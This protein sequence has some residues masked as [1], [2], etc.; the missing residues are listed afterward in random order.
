MAPGDPTAPADDVDDLAARLADP[1]LA[2]TRAEAP[3]PGDPPDV[4][5]RLAHD[6]LTGAPV[7]PDGAAV[8]ARANDL[9]DQMTTHERLHLLSGDGR[10]VRGVAEMAR[11]YNERP[12]VAGE[13]PRLGIPG[14]RFSDGPRGVVVGQATA[15][16][17]AM[18]RGASFD[19]D[20]EERV[21]DAMGA[22]CRALGANLFAGVC[23]N[24][25][26]HPAWGRAQETFG[27]DPHLLGEMGA[28]LVRGVQ[29][30]VMACV[31]HFACN[32]MEDARFRVD[33]S[34]DEDDLR[35]I[36]LP[37]FRRCVDEG[38]AAV[39][40]AYNQVNG[41]WCGHS[42]HL[43]GDVLKGEWDFDGFVM[44]DFLLGVRS[45]AAVAAGLDVEMPF[46][47]RF[48]SLGRLVRRGKVAGERVDDAARRVLRQQVR[49]AARAAQAA[50]SDG[51]GAARRYDPAVVAGEAHRA[52][53]REVAE[54]SIVLLRNETVRPPVRGGDRVAAPGTGEP[55][56]PFDPERVESMA[57]L[58]RLAAL[59]VTG[60]RGSSHVRAPSV[61]TVLDGLRAAGDRWVI[62]VAH[63]PGDDLDAARLAATTADVAVVVAGYTH[64]DEGENVL[65]RGGDRRSLTLAPHDEALIRTVAAVNPRTAVVLIGGSAIVT[66]SWREQVGAIL[67]A[68]YPGMEGG[69]ALARVLFGEV[70]PGGRLPCT[71]ARSA[72]QLP[73]FDPDARRVRYGPLHGYRLMQATGRSPAF[74]FGFGLSYTTFELGRVAAKRS[75]DGT[76][77][78]TVPVVNTG[79]RTG[80]EVVQVYL[81]EP[82][83]SERRPLRTLRAFRR[84][85]VAPGA[86]VNVTFELGADVVARTA[87]AHGGRVRIHVGRDA[88]PA[89]HRSVE[90]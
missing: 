20:L 59:P 9:L 76:V 6:P 43:L 62:S 49:F 35:D 64:R 77:R 7:P 8:E 48:R 29:R 75:W 18:A 12:Y 45:G 72:E 54:R 85:T 66:E 27:E 14:I 50:A 82:L 51:D 23:I 26:R 68:W 3:P 13:L 42:H 5:G 79:T 84:V 31:K 15:F 44:S 74:P 86:L 73:P 17:V 65:R 22:E 33:V 78:L 16:P 60:D 89:G 56:L 2:A 36:Y 11:H 63:Q 58:G 69:H 25:L 71:W 67:M 10:L 30:H 90:V 52:L 34:I 83:G 19:A 21:G 80:D 46:E 37:H 28:A 88:D 55:V 41:E 53:A 87:V 81:D 57:V 38:V 40:T 39:M 24:L 1:V 70:N 61:V 4:W 32:S 47:W